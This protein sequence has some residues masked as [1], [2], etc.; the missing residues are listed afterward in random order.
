M[1]L[2]N[3][4][5][6]DDERDRLKAEAESA[7]ISLSELLRSRVFGDPPHETAVHPQ[8]TVEKIDLD[9]AQWL[10]R[11]IKQLHA[12]GR[13]TPVARKEALAELKTS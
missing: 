12:Q 4:R 1:A 6:S 5:V 3:F 8:A 10:E 2:L 9:T 11:R 13:T 7:G